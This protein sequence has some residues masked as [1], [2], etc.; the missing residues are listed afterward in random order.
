MVSS[1]RG[2]ES[3]RICGL[4][5]STDYSWAREDF[6]HQGYLLSVGSQAS[7]ETRIAKGQTCR[8]RLAD[9]LRDTGPAMLMGFS[10]WS[11]HALADGHPLDIESMYHS[12]PFS[13]PPAAADDIVV[14]REVIANPDFMAPHRSSRLQGHR[15]SGTP[16]HDVGLTRNTPASGCHRITEE[17]SMCRM[18]ANLH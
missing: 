5:C 18:E 2:Y 1:G 12:T 14:D 7:V 16:C 10:W 9:R 4:L 17:S 13:D 15:R 11:I 3:R 8:L 6:S